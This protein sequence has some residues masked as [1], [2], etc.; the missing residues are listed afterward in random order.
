MPMSDGDLGTDSVQ[1]GSSDARSAERTRWN[2]ITELVGEA[3]NLEPAERA[4]YLS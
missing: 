4:A 1:Q 2:L 3:W